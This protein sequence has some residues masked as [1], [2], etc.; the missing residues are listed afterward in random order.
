[1]S[2][3]A[4]SP[5]PAPT[6]RSR[7]RVRQAWIARLARFATSGLSVVAFCAAEGVSTPSF[8]WWKRRLATE[9]A[10]TAAPLHCAKDAQA[11]LLPVRVAAPNPAV[12]LLLP[13]GATLRLVPGCDLTFVRCLVDALGGASC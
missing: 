13:G 8:Y 9:E 4:A 12:E 3:P 6:P 7:A 1:V 11:I 10:A 5:S 2:E